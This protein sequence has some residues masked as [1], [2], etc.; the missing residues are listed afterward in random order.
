MG[1]LSN[2][3]TD[4]EETLLIKNMRNHLIELAKKNT[5]MRYQQFSDE[6][7]LDWDMQ[8]IEDR[9]LIAKFLGKISEDEFTE[10]RPLL[11]VFIQ[12]E[13]GLPGKGFFTMAEQLGRFMPSFMDK[14]EFV[15]RERE[16]ARVYWKD[17]K[18]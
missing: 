16:Y 13:D 14:N 2:L 18:K 9:K 15:K 3:F 8:D 12:H 4:E 10:G 17:H 6:F 7:Y 1:Q 11:S 5:P